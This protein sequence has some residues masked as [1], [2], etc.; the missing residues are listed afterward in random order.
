VR[1][2]ASCWLGLGSRRPPWASR[3]ALKAGGGAPSPGPRGPRYALSPK[4]EGRVKGWGG[5]RP[6]PG[7]VGRGMPCPLSA[8]AAVGAGGGG[9]PRRS[10]SSVSVVIP[11]YPLWGGQHPWYRHLPACRPPGSWLAVSGCPPGPV[12]YGSP[13]GEIYIEWVLCSEPHHL[14]H[15]PRQPTASIDPGRPR[16]GRLCARDIHIYIQG[17]QLPRPLPRAFEPSRDA[18]PSRA[19]LPAD[20]TITPRQPRGPGDAQDAPGAR[21]PRRLPPLV[22]QRPNPSSPIPSPPRRL[23]SAHLSLPTGECSGPTGTAS[24]GPRAPPPSLGEARPEGKRPHAQGQTP[25]SPRRGRF[26]RLTTPPTSAPSSH[27]ARGPGR[28]HAESP[29]VKRLPSRPTTATSLHHH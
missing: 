8:R 11:C 20:R 2:G 14:H 7:P 3:A 6:P 26:P 5:E 21:A 12:R 24:Q 16:P 25:W 10:V 1:R 15:L 23:P 29:A 4:R 22:A 28:A 9:V 19:R 17:T 13:G 18:T 27:H